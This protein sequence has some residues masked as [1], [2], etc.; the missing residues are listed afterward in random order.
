MEFNN[1]KV[2]EL[3][4]DETHQINGGGWI[5]YALGW[6]CGKIDNALEYYSS[7]SGVDSLVMIL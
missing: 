3:T 4:K 2:C 7:L 1:L 6:V 5:S